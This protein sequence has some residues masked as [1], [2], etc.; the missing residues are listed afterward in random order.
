MDLKLQIFD[1]ISISETYLEEVEQ[2]GCDEEM[3]PIY[4]TKNNLKD[5]LNTENS[6][7]MT[8]ASEENIVYSF[9]VF[10]VIEKDCAHIKSI[11]IHNSYKRYKLGTKMI[12]Y[13]KTLFKKIS[14]YVQIVNKVAF[15]FYVRN[16]FKIIKKD[17]TYYNSLEDK[18]AYY[19][20]Y[21]E[22][23]DNLTK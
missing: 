5:E 10:T 12:C 2:I 17:D 14:L 20:I 23:D 1:K 15:N 7:L 8:I 22:D 11:C 18:G 21:N 3:L 9:L 6:Y 19:M 16:N 4:Y 13:L